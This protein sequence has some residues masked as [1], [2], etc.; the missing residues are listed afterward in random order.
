[1]RRLDSDMDL[2][3]LTSARLQEPS[4]HAGEANPVMRKLALSDLATTIIAERHD[5]L[6]RRPVNA[7]E[8]SWLLMHDAILADRRRDDTF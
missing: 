5:M 1:M 4:N 2:A 6:L 7:H 8:P 3:R